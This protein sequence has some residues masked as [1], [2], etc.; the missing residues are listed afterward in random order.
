MPR[1]LVRPRGAVACTDGMPLHHPVASPVAPCAA[2]EHGRR[3]GRRETWGPGSSG[4]HRCRDVPAM[5]ATGSGILM[6]MRPGMR[7]LTTTALP[8]KEEGRG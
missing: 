7:S 8:W 6:A 5:G 4:A 2:S 1:V 3:H